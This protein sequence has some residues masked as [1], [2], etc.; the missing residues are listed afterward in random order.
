MTGRTR[1]RLGYDGADTQWARF[2]SWYTRRAPAIGQKGDEI[3]KFYLKLASEREMQITRFYGVIE[4]SNRIGSSWTNLCLTLGALAL[5]YNRI[6]AR[7]GNEGKV[8]S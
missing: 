4:F 6:K 2:S 5:M 1:S 7:T 3:A 8:Y